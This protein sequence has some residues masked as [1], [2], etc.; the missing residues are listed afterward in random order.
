[1]ATFALPSA[2]AA[3][4]LTRQAARPSR[5]LARR[6]VAVAAATAALLAVLP[7]AA[8]QADS[9]QSHTPGGTVYAVM[10]GAGTVGGARLAVTAPAT[11]LLGRSATVT[12]TISAVPAGR[13]VRILVRDLICG[14]TRWVSRGVAR[15]TCTFR[16]TRPGG[17]R[18]TT[19]ATFYTSGRLSG[20]LSAIRQVTSV[21][22]RVSV[23]STVRRGVRDNVRI[24]LGTTAAPGATVRL[25]PGVIGAT[26]CPSSVVVRVDLSRSATYRCAITPAPVP[27]LRV[28]PQ[29]TYAATKLVGAVTTREVQDGPLLSAS[30]AEQAWR[31]ATEQEFQKALSTSVD[32]HDSAATGFEIV[33]RAHRDGWGDPAVAPMVQHL[34]ELRNAD[35]GWGLQSSWDAFGDH[36]VNPASTTYTVTTAAHAGPAVLGA[37]QHDLVS[38]AD[39]RRAVDSLLAIPTWQVPG[40]LCVSYSTSAYDTGKCVSNVSLGAAAWLKQVRDATGWSIP[41]LDTVVAGVT[42]A[43]RYLFQ[44][45][46]GYWAY[47]D[48]ANQRDLPQDP[49]HQGYTLE[50]MLDLDPSLAQT[51]TSQFLRPWWEQPSRYTMV[52]YGN[53]QSQVAFTDCTGAARSPALLEAFGSITTQPDPVARFISLQ[54]ALHGQRTIDTCFGGKPW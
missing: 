13:T 23:P 33:M 34:L 39:L 38:D 35:G 41:R 36:T 52:M 22:V 17:Y 44:K 37:W 9:G 26:G 7:A 32:T 14:T 51:T 8:A 19:K 16:P 20:T 28:A 25:V 30:A 6:L 50:S 48:L 54:Y 21:G 40:G 24:T 45:E 31:E 11:V 43:R 2:R 46:T 10:P 12:A 1:M 42:G 49:A 5:R 4:G 15:A 47:S 53:G 3:Q 18:L 27:E 29:V